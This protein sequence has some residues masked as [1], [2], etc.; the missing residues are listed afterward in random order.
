[1]MLSLSTFLATLAV[2]HAWHLDTFLN[3]SNFFDGTYW[4]F[5]TQN[6]PTHG[7]VNYVDK[8]TAA[9]KGYISTS[10]SDK[11]TYI[12]CDH[13]NTANGRGLRFCA[14]RIQ[15]ALRLRFD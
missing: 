7:Y 11:P 5:I 12:G 15:K 6:D 10:G 13:T 4:N 8:A 3:G 9:A 1:M 2:S 14:R